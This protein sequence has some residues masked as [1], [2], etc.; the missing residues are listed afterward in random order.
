MKS[1]IRD[2]VWFQLLVVLVLLL[3]LVVLFL[4]PGGALLAGGLW[5]WLVLLLCFWAL[6]ALLTPAG[7]MT[8]ETGEPEPRMLH[9]PEQ[10]EVVREVM[11]VRLATEEAGVRT[12]HGPLREP[13]TTAYE[14]LKRAFSRQTVPMLQQDERHGA[15]IALLPNPV[16]EAALERPVRPSV[17]WLLFALTALTTTWAGAAQQ[18]V[19]L[20]QEPRR[21]AVGLPYALGLLAVL[22]VH[23]LGHYFAARYHG[24]RVTPPYFIPV[25]FALGTF[26]AFIQMRSPTED[27]RALFDVAVAGPLAGLVVAVPLLLIGLESSA[28]VP[29][30]VIGGWITALEG[31]AAPEGTAPPVV[32]GGTSAG[33]SLLLALL[34]KLALPEALRYGWVLQLSPLAFAGWLGVFITG[35]NLLPIGQLDGGHAA[36]ALFGHRS[37][38]VVSSVAMW[39]LLLLGIFVW[40]GLLMWALIVFFIAGDPTPPLN[41]LTPLAPGRRALGHAVF[42]ILLLIVVPL[43]HALWPAAGIHCPY[44]G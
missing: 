1:T 4:L 41:D 14:K 30:E 16:E 17:N 44:V 33:S 20:L 28:V 39:S 38:V 22:G 42:V 13:A 40:P 43:P 2:E 23:E 34:A 27:R 37:G 12:F 6:W 24:I 29:G 35:L 9:E 7:T 5:F 15:V 10:P 31:A 3:P 18:G 8:A 36:R 32:S 11:K 21:F 26:G 25:P 19:N